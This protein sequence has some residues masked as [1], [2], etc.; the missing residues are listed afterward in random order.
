M[1]I[2]LVILAFFL[3]PVFWIGLIRSYLD[4]H[5]RIT[6]TRKQFN[7]AVYENHY[8]LRHFWASTVLLG[9]VLSAFSGLV[10]MIL[11]LSWL[12]IYELIA[13][14]SLIL[15]PGFVMPVLMVTV[16][17]LVPLLLN[18]KAPRM[19][20][21]NYLLITGLVIV[22]LG[23]FI[24]FTAGRYNV[25]KT[26]NDERGHRIVGY[27]FKEL[28][29]VPMLVMI[30][31]NVIQHWISFY[32]TF[33]INGHRVSLLLIPIVLG[34]RLTVFKHV[35]RKVFKRLSGWLVTLGIAG[36]L[37]AVASYRW[38]VI[39]AASLVGLLLL[40]W[41]ILITVKEFDKKGGRYYS[42][43]INGVRVVAIE[44]NTPAAKMNLHVGDVILDANHQ[45]VRNED[46]FY[47]ALE[48]HPTYCRLRVMNRNQR[49]ILTGTAIYRGSP[50]EI[51][52]V[53]F[54]SANA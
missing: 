6:R 10:G 15:I 22:A 27:P 13:G 45:A 9:I 38:P 11:P 26:F 18:S 16:S 43:V 48:T 8:E 2:L 35:S 5:T 46:E 12:L 44:P 49:I 34:L 31:G 23:L 29:I 19:A 4:S 3:Q 14:L 25:P 37:L 20:G 53:L 30:P 33:V 54:R 50:H 52:V 40:S 47:E 51:G 28:S 21:H 41:W 36:M 39:I 1:K 7:T 42:E 24:G 17:S 32:P